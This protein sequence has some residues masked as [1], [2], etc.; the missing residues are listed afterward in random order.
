[1]S[2]PIYASLWTHIGRMGPKNINKVRELYPHHWANCKYV[3]SEIIFSSE[4]AVAL[5]PVP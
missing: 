3:D 4:N 5:V 2:S 1:M